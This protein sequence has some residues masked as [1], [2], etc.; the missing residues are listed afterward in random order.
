MSFQAASFVRSFALRAPHHVAIEDGLDGTR[1]DYGSLDRAARAIAASL[2]ALGVPP[3]GRVAVVARNSPETAAH[4]LGILYGGFALVP[5]PSGSVERELREAMT[6]TGAHAL[7]H[8][9]SAPDTTYVPSAGTHRIGALPAC[10]PLPAPCVVSPSADALLLHTSGTFGA[11]KVARIS[12]ASL[13]AHTASLVHHA[14][15]L[16]ATDR[17][18]LVLPLAHS[19]GLRVGLLGSAFAGATIV[20]L[21]RF[22][23]P[24]VARVLREGGITFFPGVPTMFSALGRS[25]G[26]IAAP[27]LRRVISA[28]AKLAPA[29]REAAERVLAVPIAEAYGLTE[30]TFAAVDGEGPVPGTVGR[31]VPGVEI[32]IL[33]ARGD[34]LPPSTLGEI[35]VRGHN[36]MTG[37]LG[38]PDLALAD[39]A[40]LR[41]GD[42]GEL[43]GE[44]R[45]RVIDRA[46]DLVVRNGV[47]VIPSSVE[48]AVRT[49]PGV[50]DVLVVGI[51]CAH[52]G[53][54][55]V[56]VVVPAGPLDES[57]LARSFGQVLGKASRP[58]RVAYVDALPIGASGKALRRV[59]R[60]RLVSGSLESKAIPYGEAP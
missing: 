38:E 30:A 45:L 8:D 24:N 19:Y 29:V 41:T 60:D 40:L 54:E 51:P 39:G 26:S 27:T 47:N 37:Y 15:R 10:E 42:L 16:S 55:V 49:C 1:L 33:D 25:G 35:A 9:G 18:L 34:R 31:A 44:G 46:K 6:R 4:V 5:L 22:E 17:T 20:T 52:R 48:E 23:T 14:L 2:V 36:V 7:L 53:E 57:S 59:V 21:P 56:A 43:D 58:G 32:A 28:G 11:P 13:V 50:A 12:H 3:G